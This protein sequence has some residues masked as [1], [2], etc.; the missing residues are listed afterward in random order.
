MQVAVSSQLRQ[1]SP[2]SALIAALNYIETPLTTGMCTQCGSDIGVLDLPG[3]S[4]LVN[5][6]TDARAP[7]WSKQ[8]SI[9]RWTEDLFCSPAAASVDLH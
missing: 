2:R 4:S 6:R 7:A 9:Q 3:R 5:M 1:D 8:P